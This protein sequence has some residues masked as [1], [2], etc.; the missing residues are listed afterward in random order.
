MN[1]LKD[2][3]HFWFSSMLIM[4]TYGRILFTYWVLVLEDIT[5]PLLVQHF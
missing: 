2:L 3:L 4:L 1:Q 5:S